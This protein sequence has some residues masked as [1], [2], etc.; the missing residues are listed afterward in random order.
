LEYFHSPK[1]DF[2]IVDAT[3]QLF[4]SL[5]QVLG[6]RELM[7]IQGLIELSFEFTPSSLVFLSSIRVC[8]IS[9]CDVITPS[10]ALACLRLFLGSLEILVSGLA[11][12]FG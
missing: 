8:Y 6:A 2:E 10:I 3:F 4:E 5:I 12:S 11:S 7:I 9:L 1:L